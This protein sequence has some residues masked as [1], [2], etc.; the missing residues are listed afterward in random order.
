MG[1][2]WIKSVQPEH[3]WVTQAYASASHFEAKPNA[4]TSVA[5]MQRVALNFPQIDP[6]VSSHSKPRLRTLPWWAPPWPWVQAHR[7]L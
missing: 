4:V 3:V 7:S 1:N 6:L 5:G 2:F